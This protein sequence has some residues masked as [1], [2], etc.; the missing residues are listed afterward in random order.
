MRYGTLAWNHIKKN[1]TT[2]KHAAISRLTDSTRRSY[3]KCLD[4]WFDWY[5]TAPAPK[6]CRHFFSA[7]SVKL[8]LASRT[9]LSASTMNVALSAIRSLATDM[10]KNGL[11]ELATVVSIWEIPRRKHQ[12]ALRLVPS[13]AAIRVLFSVLNTRSLTGKRDSAILMLLFYCGLRRSEVCALQFKH[14]HKTTE[15]RWV[16]DNLPTLR[17]RMLDVEVRDDVKAAKESNR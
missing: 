3:E 12:S 10:N 14:I 8:Y 4:D 2:W 7:E 6:C 15:N 1:W 13:E 9:D 11:L 16:I 5:D 17:G